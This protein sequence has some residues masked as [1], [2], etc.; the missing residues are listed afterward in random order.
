LRRVLNQTGA[1]DV[2]HL[3]RLYNSIEE[4]ND[5]LYREV[6]DTNIAIEKTQEDIEELNKYV[7][8]HELRAKVQLAKKHSA[9]PQVSQVRHTRSQK[10]D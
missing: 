9:Q 7:K 1:K 6:A 3:I 4:T 5:E 10:C 2:D 8:K